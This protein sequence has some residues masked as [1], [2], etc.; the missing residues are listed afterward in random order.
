MICNVVPR[1]LPMPRPNMSVLA[2]VNYEHATRAFL[3]LWVRSPKSPLKRVPFLFLGCF[4]KALKP[5]ALKP[6]KPAVKGLLRPWH[7]ETLER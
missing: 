3:F 5:E 6:W 4:T 7:F 1:C 2:E